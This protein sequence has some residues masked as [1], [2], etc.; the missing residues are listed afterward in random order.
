MNEY[1][2]HGCNGFLFSTRFPRPLANLGDAEQ[3]AGEIDRWNRTFA[4]DWEV[5]RKAI[6]ELVQSGT[7]PQ[8][9]GPTVMRRSLVGSALRIFTG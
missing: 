6:V 7:M 1:I 5:G 2:A 3:L 8:V 9:A 4:G